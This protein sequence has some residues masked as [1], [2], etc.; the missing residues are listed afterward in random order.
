MRKLVVILC[1]PVDNLNMQEALARIEEFIIEGRKTGKTHQIATVNADFVVKALTDPELRHLLQEADMATAD[2]MPLVWGAR[3]LGTPLEERVAGADMVPALA[4]IAARKGY[5]MFF[6]GAAPGVAGRAGEILRARHPA[7]NIVGIVSPPE[8]SVLEIDPSIIEKIKNT[9]PDILLVAFGNPKQEKWIGMYGRELGVPVMI[10]V[11]G[12]FDFIA[13]HTK[14]APLWMQNIGLEWLHRL[15]QEP[16][17]LWKRYVVDL[18]SFG[19]FFVRQWWMTRG[20]Q[21]PSPLLPETDVMVIDKIAI[22][23]IVGRVD[24]TNSSTITQKGQEA[25]EAAPNL[26]VNLEQTAFL[27][28]TGIGALVGLA[29]RARDAGGQMK[30]AAVP[31]SVMKVLTMLRLNQFFEFIKHIEEGLGF[32]SS[33]ASKSNERIGKWRVYHVPRRF[34]AE[35]GPEIKETCSQLLHET[36]HLILDFTDTTFLGSAGLAAL[37]NINRLAQEKG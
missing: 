16:K 22:L 20:E 12:T 35:S 15:V 37:L 33:K 21:I 27:D 31:E 11:G 29:K 1:A 26:I 8:G 17:R 23:N 28:S 32:S 36:S 34:D 5:S 9:K 3:L 24:F 4:E 25:L 6:L 2:G 14:R 7:L 13:G 18:F 30:L 19:S 10:G